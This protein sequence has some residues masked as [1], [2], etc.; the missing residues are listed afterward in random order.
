MEKLT[1]ENI[2]PY[3]PYGL[4]FQSK[5]NYPIIGTPE[6]IEIMK[7]DDTDE[8]ITVDITIS[9]LSK[10]ESERN[11]SLKNLTPII[12]PMDLTKSI[13]IDGK[14]VIP[15]V[16]L[17]KI[18]G[19]ICIYGRIEANKGQRLVYH[20]GGIAFCFNPTDGAFSYERITSA[21]NN[22]DIGH[23]VFNQLTLFKWLYANKFDVDGLIEKGLAIDVNTLETNPY[24]T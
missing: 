23:V 8:I 6:A 21:A 7:D 12:R 24:N 1:L 4:K 14:E 10:K 17:A 9:D 19:F 11:L 15:I 20:N 5:S 18:A 3:L 22:F 16:E 2:A 13:T